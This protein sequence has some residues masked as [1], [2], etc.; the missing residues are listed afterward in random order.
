MA[1]TIKEG[2]GFPKLFLD[3]EIIP[4]L[5]AK[6]GQVEEAN[7]YCICGCTEPKM[8]NRD[9]ITTGCAWVNLGA[10]L[11][12]ALNDGKIRKYNKRYGVGTGDPRDL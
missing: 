6:G 8:V 12:M 9:A 10:I 5:V 2:T 11:E 4:L 3:E 1:E 7:D